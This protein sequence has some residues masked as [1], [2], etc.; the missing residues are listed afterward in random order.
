MPEHPK[1]EVYEAADGEWRARLIAGNGQIVLPPEGHRDPTD[2][3][4]AWVNAAALLN[5]A[6][7]AGAIHVLPVD[8]DAKHRGSN[9]TG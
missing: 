6:I 7:E 8:T 3:V 1:L 9:P 2:V 5:E 4:R